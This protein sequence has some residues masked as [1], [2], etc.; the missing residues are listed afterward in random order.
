MKPS[1]PIPTNLNHLGFN[2]SVP[3][4]FQI[5]PRIL[6]FDCLLVDFSE[7]FHER[8]QVGW[9]HLLELQICGFK[10]IFILLDFLTSHDL[11]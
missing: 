3:K 9:K 7:D 8:K 10:D 2:D 1:R 5:K 11:Y 6:Q 4:N